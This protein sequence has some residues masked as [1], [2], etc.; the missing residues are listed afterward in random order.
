MAAEWL[1]DDAQ[2]RTDGPSTMPTD[3]IVPDMFIKPPELKEK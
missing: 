1:R 3:P 2:K